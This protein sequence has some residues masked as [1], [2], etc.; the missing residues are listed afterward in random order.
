MPRNLVTGQTEPPVTTAEAK[1]HLRV[2]GEAND[3]KIDGLIDVATEWAE[4]ESRRA[5]MP[6]TWDFTFDCFSSIM[7]I[8]LP[9]LQ[10]ITSIKYIDADGAEQTLASSGYDVDTYSEPG[11]VSLAY[12]QSWPTIRT[13]L[14]A[15][16]IR[17]VCGYATG[18]IPPAITQAMKMRIATNFENTEDVS[19]G[20][21]MTT[22]PLTS[23]HLIAPYK[24]DFL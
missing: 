1:A 16:T 4:T 20:V 5:L 19:A 10:S 9:P 8:P 18:S 12:N 7:E 11:R 23:M 2:T 3:S 24:V 17:A 22:T 15:V 21:S 6:Q 14:N 13:Q